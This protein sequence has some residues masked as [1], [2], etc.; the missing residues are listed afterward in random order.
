MFIMASHSGFELKANET[1]DKSVSHIHVH[2][3]FKT[4][5]SSIPSKIATSISHSS[6]YEQIQAHLYTT[7][8]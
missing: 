2:T 4:T 7:V 3:M 6:L 5:H 8:L 1:K